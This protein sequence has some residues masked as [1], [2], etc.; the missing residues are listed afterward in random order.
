MQQKM[1]DSKAP[2]DYTEKWVP[3]V[4]Q[5]TLRTLLALAASKD[6]HMGQ[7][8]IKTA[9]LNGTPKEELYVRQPKGFELGDPTQLCRLV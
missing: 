8:D 6:L 3:V 9:F 7:M 4:R 2:D 5:A 1:P